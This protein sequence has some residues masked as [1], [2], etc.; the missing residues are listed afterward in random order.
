MRCPD[1]MG[2]GEK[3]YGEIRGMVMYSPCGSCDGT[4]EMTMGESGIPR[5]ENFLRRVVDIEDRMSD[6][7]LDID[8]F[9]RNLAV[10]GNAEL[11]RAVIEILHYVSVS[12]CSSF[13]SSD[14]EMLGLFD[15][16][17]DNINVFLVLYRG[18]KYLVR[19]KIKKCHGG[20]TFYNS[21]TVTEHD[22]EK[23]L[24]IDFMDDFVAYLQ[25]GYD[26]VRKYY[27]EH[28]LMQTVVL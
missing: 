1:S 12:G 23:Y 21:L 28:P 9:Y 11:K 25:G 13:R 7:G 15:V 5:T 19:G 2:T 18:K 20:R 6:F 3:Y 10:L 8:L 16:E 26:A 17:N 4:G 24:V 22:G 14:P 27:A